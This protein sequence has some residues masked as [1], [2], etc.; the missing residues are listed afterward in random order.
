MDQNAVRDPVAA[1]RAALVRGAWGEA[2][3]RF[4]AAIERSE[5]ADVWEGLGWAGWWLGDGALT[6]RARERAYRAFRAVNDAGG[7]GRM[8]AFLAA[9]FLEFRG[10][11]AVA[12]GWLERA[13]RLLDGAPESADHGWLALHEGSFVLGRGELE[14]ASELA[15]LGVRLGS[16]LPMA[17]LEAVGLALQGIAFV[18]G[19]QVE[20]GM[21]RLDEASVIAVGEDL[22][23]P[24]SAAWVLCYL[25]GA[26][27]GVGD[28]P[29]ATQWCEAM[30]AFTERWGGRQLLGLC[31]SAYGSVLAAGG[32]WTTADTE[33]TAAVGDLEASRPGMVA[34]GLVR[35][36]ELRACQGRTEEARAL[37]GRAGSHGL[38][39][40]GLGSLTLDGGDPAAAADAAER[41]LRRL[42]EG[43][44]LDRVS[45]LELLVRARVRLGD[46]DAAAAA[47]AELACA[48]TELGTRYMRG[49][50]R[51]VAG[52]VA[53]AQGDYERARRDCED[54][55]DYLGDA[56]ACY[57][58]ARARLE[59]A[60]ALAGLGRHEGADTEAR[61]ALDVLV[62]LGAAGDVAQARLLVRGDESLDAP[63][64]L[65]GELTARELDVLRL[66]ADGLSDA[67]IAE[68]LVVSQHTVHRHVANVRTKLRLPSRAAAVAYATRAG[69]L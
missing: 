36:A 19:G 50:A 13:H 63:G 65:L 44:V 48:A 12:S 66:V 31:R 42:P 52:E 33:L 46:L 55:I 8:A 60:R 9:D 53:A 25:I 64:R 40:L 14:G 10:D 20:V 22:E 1:A 7:A 3:E 17:D 11:D 27:E 51:L 35:L 45:A 4:E 56:G 5:S 15:A 2:R 61:A 6:I 59:L 29:R 30:R 43:V 23:L 69:L 54:A 38:A 49:R 67:E 24:F 37:F 47:S 57:H 28:F 21:R 32:D 62:G 26:C 68:R 18:R 16:E 58:V 41:V 34:G 39:V